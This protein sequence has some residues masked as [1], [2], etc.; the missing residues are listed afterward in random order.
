MAD[1][2]DSYRCYVNYGHEFKLL[3][4]DFPSFGPGGIENSSKSHSLELRAGNPSADFPGGC[5]RV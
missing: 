3:F 4:Y 5:L 1:K 2:N